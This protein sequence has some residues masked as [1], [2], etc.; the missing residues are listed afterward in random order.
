MRSTHIRW[1]PSLL[2]LSLLACGQGDLSVV[3]G[4]GVKVS[5]LG[6]SSRWSVTSVS[7]AASPANVTR[8]LTPDA[9]GKVTG[10]LLLPVG[11]QT[12]VATAFASNGQGGVKEIGSGRATVSVSK[13]TSAA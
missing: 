1:L 10:N 8:S 13:G 9:S 4:G 3:G 6:L 7:V 5:I 2:V 11:E 12:L